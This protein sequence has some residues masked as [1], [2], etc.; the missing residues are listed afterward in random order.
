MTMIDTSTSLGD[1]V[2][3]HPR[4]AG[5]LERRGLDYCC[6]G[7]RTLAE[8]AA[9]LG[10]DIDALVADL[11]GL[12]AG[13]AQEAWATMGAVQLVDHIV[14]SHHRYLWDEL[15]RLVALADKV[16]NVHGERHPELAEVSRLTAAVQTDLEPHMLKEEDV[17]FPRVRHLAVAK[18]LDHHGTEPHCCDS[19]DTPIS[20]LL[21]EHDRVG[22]LLAELR[23]VTGE[24]QPPADGCASYQALY[25]GL[26]QLEADTHLHVHKENNLLFPAVV[27]IERRLGAP[28]S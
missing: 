15:P 8:S 11:N 23:A 13:D 27:A 14:E 21:N 10:L 9:D 7:A 3:N 22:D 19:L 2:T 20:V 24:Y 6:G 18:T 16:F 4:L 5:E 17:I 26:A 1:L 25:A 28:T 12:S